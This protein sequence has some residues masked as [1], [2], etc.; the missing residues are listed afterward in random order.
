[1]SLYD[2][3]QAP[4]QLGEPPQARPRRRLPMTVGIAAAVVAAA[5][6]TL[7]YGLLHDS[8]RPDGGPPPWPAPA[9]PIA[10]IQAAGLTVGPMGMAE[11]YHAHL[12]VFVDG[13]PVTVAENIGVLSKDE[14]T[15][16]HTH[17]T[18]GVIHVETHRK[19]DTFTLGQLFQ[20]WGV[21][22][23]PHQ[24]G[25]LKAEDG[26]ALTAYVNGKP[27]SGDP[28]G[29]VIKAHEEIAL[30]Y[31]PPDPSFTPPAGYT[32]KPDE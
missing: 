4:E 28:A 7:G 3:T 21:T 13:K 19:G 23:S 6:A 15:P 16:L 31:G 32:F 30:V 12:D 18:R 5:L 25:T 1:M 22:L 20:Q 29:I 8:P 11:H 17:D 27:I 26:K 2:V 10:G 9:D 14:M 24:I